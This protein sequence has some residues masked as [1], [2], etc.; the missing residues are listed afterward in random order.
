MNDNFV[1]SS[2]G[3]GFSE[4]LKVNCMIFGFVLRTFTPK[5]SH[6]QIF[7]EL[8]TQKGNDILLPKR[9]KKLGVTD[10]VLERTC[11]EKY[12]KTEKSGFVS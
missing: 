6:A 8:A 10:F 11:L 3:V 9:Q 1:I 12:P 7:F 5:S 2:F 4:V